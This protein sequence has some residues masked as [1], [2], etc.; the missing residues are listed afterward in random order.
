MIPVKLTIQGLYSYQK[1]QVIDFA[2]LTGAHLFG[3]FGAVGS[4]KSSI[5]DAITFALY[6]ETERMHARDN[7]SYNMMNLKSDELL[8]EFI[9]RDRK[10]DSYLAIVKGRRNSKRFDDVKTLERSAFR[11]TDGQWMPVEM[12]QLQEAIGVSYENFK[13]T[14]IIPQGRFQEFLQLG[15]KDRTQMM[16]ELF[17]LERFELFYKTSSL[18]RKNNAQKQLLEGKLQQLGEVRPGQVEEAQNRLAELQKE[19]AAL[20]SQLEKRQKES[21]ALAQLSEQFN[22]LEIVGKKHEGLLLQEASFKQKEKRVKEYEECQAQFKN[23][24]ESR[25]ET[26]VKIAHLTSQLKT[27]QG[28]SKMLEGQLETLRERFEKVK[29]DYD[30]R[31]HL[32]QEADELQ[33]I[34]KLIELEEAHKSLAARINKGDEVCMETEARAKALKLQKDKAGADL[35]T[36]KKTMPDMAELSHAREWFANQKSISANTR[37]T[38]EEQATTKQEIEKIDE[39]TRSLWMN[40]DFRDIPENTPWHEAL[41][42]LEKKMVLYKKEI[43]GIDRET[44][45]LSVQAKLKEYA[46][47]LEEGKPCPLCGATSHPNILSASDVSEAMAALQEKKMALEQAIQSVEKHS[48]TL[49]EIAANLK[50]RNEQNAKISRRLEELK[51]KSAAHQKLFKWP[52]YPDQATLDK[53]FADA[54]SLQKNTSE[55][56]AHLEKLNADLEQE[57]LSLEKYRAGLE[58]IKHQ[59]TGNTAAIETLSSQ[60]QR[61]HRKDF[62]GQTPAQMHEL[63]KT[64]VQKL[65]NTEQEF[66]KLNNDISAISEKKNKLS[67]LIEANLS[68]LKQE[69]TTKAKIDQNIQ[70]QLDKSAYTNIETVKEILARDV[71]IETEKQKIQDYHQELQFARRQLEQ[72]KN[73]IGGKVYDREG[74]EKLKQQIIALNER[75]EAGNQEVGKIKGDIRKLQADLTQQREL[76]KQLEALE[77]RGEDIKTLKQLFKGS[78]FVNYVSS[79][80]LQNLCQSANERFYK[81]TRQKLSLEITDDNN[82]HVRDFMNGGKTRSVKTLSGGQTFQASLSLA[83]SLADSIQ[84]FTQSSQNFFFLDE[85]FGALDKESLEVVFETLKSLRNENRIV[86]VISHVKKCRRKSTYTSA[87]KTTRETGSTI[88]NSWE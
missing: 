39:K 72:I 6:G 13:R 76:K 67:G 79:V 88:I 85:G 36:L 87:W 54:E 27:D 21:Q 77:L 65:S 59:Q 35:K 73:E 38:L 47:N 23:L 68:V 81:L 86:G 84:Q 80:H 53:A 18:E 46:N 48:A 33:K 49:R 8:I 17:N 41:A 32:K 20:V 30:Q 10:D 40:E 62:E 5:L 74:H 45:H 43:D 16:K 31:D 64:I 44:Q 1:K 26:A 14:I 50:I 83:L 22:Q 71:D 34:G 19:I 82:F 75:I 11:Q 24:L 69:E 37:E 56:E 60:I 2:M 51:E 66:N 15:N 25:E 12:V 57:T 70:Q 63:S 7:R 58:Q 9:F 61:L 55:K 52:K 78:G 4:G 3:I 29:S 42:L 28:E